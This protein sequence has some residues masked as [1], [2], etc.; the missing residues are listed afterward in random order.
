ML[1][2]EVPFK[3]R[4]EHE[5]RNNIETGVIRFPESVQVSLQIKD[6]IINCLLNDSMKRM[7]VK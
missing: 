1:F 7:G 2:G 3:G 6:F 5:L 4:T